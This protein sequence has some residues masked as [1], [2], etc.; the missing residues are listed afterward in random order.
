MTD[1]G[2]LS[3]KEMSQDL[4]NALLDVLMQRTA[5]PNAANPLA[6]IQDVLNL[7]GG[8]GGGGGGVGAK[9]EHA[10][11]AKVDADFAAPAGPLVDV[12]GTTLN[13]IVPAGQSI[14]VV[15]VG[16]VTKTAGGTE[17]ALDVDGALYPVFLEAVALREH[18]SP[19][20]AVALGA[21]NRSV[22]VKMGGAGGGTLHAS[23]SSPFRVIAIWSGAAPS[24][25]ANLV[26]D[27][28][29][30]TNPFNT[31]SNTFV[32]VPGTALAF[33]LDEARQVLFIAD[34]T[35]RNTGV[36]TVKAVLGIKIDGVD[37]P[38][39]VWKSLNTAAEE[40]GKMA[41]FKG[42]QLLAGPHTAEIIARTDP[43]MINP[44]TW[45]IDGSADAPT[46]LRAVY[47]EP[48]FGIGSL[49]KS[50]STV[51]APYSTPSTIFTVVPGSVIGVT[52]KVPQVVNF[53]AFGTV[54]ADP[55][56]ITDFDAVIGI[57]VDGVDYPGTRAKSPVTDGTDKM[58]VMAEVSVALASGVHT[59]EIILRTPTGVAAPA[60]LDASA[61][62]PARLTAIYTKAES[63]PQTLGYIKATSLVLGDHSGA[64][65]VPGTTLSFTLT[66]AQDVLIHLQ[67][68][69]VYAN[70]LGG[71]GKVSLRHTNPLLV[72]TDYRIGETFESDGGDFVAGSSGAAGSL[73]LNLAA[74]T[75]TFE[76]LAGGNTS[77]FAPMQVHAIA[78]E[79]I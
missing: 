2:G 1:F 77:I 53:R 43:A 46:T 6:T 28:I 67:S 60:Y 22:K 49:Q 50:E 21:G 15:A 17:M 52:L 70:V 64:G 44:N 74:G 40:H 57:R 69:G 31:Q 48:V 20:V 32:S 35:L 12:P 39:Q 71:Q 26:I 7:G 54:Q 13:F 18:V 66:A 42:I 25:A 11:L 63:F 14:V 37:Y 55:A 38:L 24:R 34:G 59:A 4:K 72:V 41:L 56:V 9:L 36:E 61:F 79:P 73:I 76:I 10:S 3:V 16:A 68:G 51:V 19:V 58:G 62:T 47:A 75:H 33:T 8:G 78:Q 29:A 23:A 30:D 45:F 65:V 27:E 5:M